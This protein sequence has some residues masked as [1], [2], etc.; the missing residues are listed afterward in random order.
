MATEKVKAL[1]EE[2]LNKIT[3]YLSSVNNLEYWE[4]HGDGGFWKPLNDKVLETFGNSLHLYDI[5]ISPKK[6]TRQFHL[7]EIDEF[8]KWLI[9]NGA[10]I[11]SEKSREEAEKHAQWLLDN[12]KYDWYYDDKGTATDPYN[13]NRKISYY[14]VEKILERSGW[15]PH[16]V[17]WFSIDCGNE[18][19]YQLILKEGDWV[20]KEGRFRN[21]GNVNLSNSAE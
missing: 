17:Y 21:T 11:D 9:E 15:E 8:R 7:K 20:I 18:Y 1:L 10:V 16:E 12:G 13:P 14:T 5:R 6:N 4:D 2:K 19:C 3:D